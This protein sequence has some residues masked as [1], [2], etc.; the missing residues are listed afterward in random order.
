METVRCVHIFTLNENLSLD[1]PVTPRHDIS[2]QQVTASCGLQIELNSI[3]CEKR[4]EVKFCINIV[5]I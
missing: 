5:T 3:R 2:T 1:K 4:T